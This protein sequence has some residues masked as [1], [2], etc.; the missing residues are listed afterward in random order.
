L[1]AGILFSPGSLGNFIQPQRGPKRYSVGT[2]VSTG[3]PGKEVL[4]W[5]LWPSGRKEKE[6]GKEREE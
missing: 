2:T 3:W 6:S 4:M 1:S 5:G